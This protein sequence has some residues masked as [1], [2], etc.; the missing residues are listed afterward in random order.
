M[1]SRPLEW[2]PYTKSSVIFHP[3]T[4]GDSWV[5]EM[6]QDVGGIID[7]NKAILN[8][9]RRKSDVRRMASIPIVVWTELKRN[10][11]ADDPKR[12]KKWLNDPENSAFRTRPGKV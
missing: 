3:E 1:E 5:E 7:H 10:G 9:D 11:I 6:R 2:N 4:D 12:L 8:L